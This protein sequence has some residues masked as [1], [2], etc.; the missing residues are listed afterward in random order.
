MRIMIVE[1]EDLVA[2]RIARLSQKVHGSRHVSTVIKSTIDAAMTYLDNHSIDMLLLDLNMNGRDGFDILKRAVAASFHTIIISANTDKAITAFEYGVLDFVGKPFSEDR[3]RQAFSKYEGAKKDLAHAARYLSVRKNGELILLDIEEVNY[4][5]ASGAYSE[6]HL[7]S[8]GSFVHDKSLGKLENILPSY[9]IRVHKSCIVNRYQILSFRCLGQN[10]YDVVMQNS[11][12][13][14]V[15]R[16]K[17]R[18]IKRH[19]CH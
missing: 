2:E 10:R 13:L 9:F 14:P 12:V 7:L 18:E 17:Y 4:I 11:Q 3:L 15:S 5:Y 16:V 1:D 8:G 19:P 6:I